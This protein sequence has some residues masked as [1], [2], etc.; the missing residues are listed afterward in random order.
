MPIERKKGANSEEIAAKFQD[1]WSQNRAASLV[2]HS[3]LPTGAYSPWE[4]VHLTIIS[5]SIDIQVTGDLNSDT[6]N[7]IH[8]KTADWWG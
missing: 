5:S 7:V 3:D 8:A 1:F 4:D 2:F 6:Q